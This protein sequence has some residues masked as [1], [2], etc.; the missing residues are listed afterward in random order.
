MEAKNFLK[1][2]LYNSLGL[3]KHNAYY[4]LFRLVKMA[5]DKI[6]MERLVLLSLTMRIRCVPQGKHGVLTNEKI[7]PR[8]SCDTKSYC[9]L[10]PMSSCMRQLRDAA[11]SLFWR[12]LRGQTRTMQQATATHYDESCLMLSQ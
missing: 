6:L 9:E 3:F 2:S 12:S 10:V 5:K 4:I 8:S 1:T 7:W 11:L